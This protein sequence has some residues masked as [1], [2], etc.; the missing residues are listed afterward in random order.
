MSESK[1]DDKVV[2]RVRAQDDFYNFVGQSWL[3]N[4]PAQGK[5]FWGPGVVASDMV[6]AQVESIISDWKK[7]DYRRL[8]HEQKLVIDLYRAY[9]NRDKSSAQSLQA[10]VALFQSAQQILKKEGLA[11]LAGW[12]SFFDVGLGIN[13][14]ADI[15]LKNSQ[16]YLLQLVGELY[17]LPTKDYYLDQDNAK[18]KNIRKKYIKFINSYTQDFLRTIRSVA[19]TSHNPIDISVFEDSLKSKNLLSELILDI[20]IKLAKADWSTSK[21]Q[22]SQSTYNLY[23]KRRLQSEYDFDWSTYFAQLGISHPEDLVVLQPDY[24][25][26]SLE[27]FHKLS[28]QDLQRYLAW[29]LILHLGFLI[30][31]NLNLAELRFFHETLYGCSGIQS[32]EKRSMQAVKYDFSRILAREYTRRHYS[33]ERH[34]VAQQIAN[35]VTSNFR[36][37]LGQTSWL[38]PTSRQYAQRKLDK[39]VVNLGRPKAWRSYKALDSGW[40]NPVSAKLELNR[41]NCQQTLGWLEQSPKRQNFSIEAHEFEAYANCSLLNINFTARSLQLHH[42][43]QQADLPTNLGLIGSTIGHELMHHFDSTGLKYDKNGNFN[44]WMSSKEQK[45]FRS[46]YR[47]LMEQAS[48]HQV[49]EG[50]YMDGRQVIDEFIA[51]LGGLQIVVAAINREYAKPKERK[52]ALQKLFIGHTIKRFARTST[53]WLLQYAKSDPHPDPIFNVNGVLTH[54]PEFYQVFDVKPTDQMYLPPEKRIKLF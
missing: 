5:S 34:Q 33:A 25:A 22:D 28:S 4:N 3:K 38:S 18:L 53:E 15:D 49:T 29:K 6:S 10:L 37:M 1:K 45:S 2:G 8:N 14:Y 16:R 12:L 30:K 48:K 44:P 52:V 26:V 7:L 51:D 39:I 35:K 32:L 31:D 43:R 40:D 11:G 23:S 46:M 17:S 36:E 13:Y 27:I 9:L 42:Y 41:F 24:L 19:T 50:V 21:A 20:E 54:I 47:S